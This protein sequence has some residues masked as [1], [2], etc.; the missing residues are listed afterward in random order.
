MRIDLG[1]SI[2]G[3]D[4]KPSTPY[5]HIHRSD[6]ENRIKK[7]PALDPWT[8][9][10]LLKKVAS[11]PDNALVYF[12]SKINQIVTSALNER[13]RIK[14]GEANVREEKAGNGKVVPPPVG[15][16]RSGIRIE[17][18]EKEVASEYDP[19]G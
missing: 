18:I 15:G 3:A 17:E 1:F 7:H 2:M 19:A 4:G 11:Y 8:K 16:S 14:Q 13:T 6:V 5:I 12:I 9:E 10:Y